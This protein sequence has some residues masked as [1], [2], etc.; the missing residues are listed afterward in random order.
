LG[1]VW[2]VLGIVFR[3]I[4]F[5]FGFFFDFFWS[6]CLCYCDW[7]TVC[8]EGFAACFSETG[9]DFSFSVPACCF[10]FVLFLAWESFLEIIPRVAPF[11]LGVVVNF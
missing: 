6:V 11:F 3:L 5:F 8:V 1:C 10:N 7:L 9:A 2:F 4:C